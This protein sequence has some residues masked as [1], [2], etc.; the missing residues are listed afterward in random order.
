MKKL[1]DPLK[2]FLFALIGALLIY[3]YYRC[4]QKPTQYIQEDK[5]INLKDYLRNIE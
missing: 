1:S 4:S 3:C 5:T 2:V